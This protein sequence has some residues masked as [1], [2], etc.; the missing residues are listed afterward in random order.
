MGPSTGCVVIE[1]QHHDRTNHGHDHAVEIKTGDAAHPDRAEEGASD[2]RP[3]NAEDDV[4]KEKPWP[5]LL[6]ILLA[7]K[8]EMSPKITY[9]IRDMMH[10][11][12]WIKTPDFMVGPAGRDC[13]RL[14]HS[15]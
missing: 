5:V 9:P 3:D 11:L 2:N 6:T 13:S 1:H 4:D 14:R 7:M 15:Y 12:T 8:P 10:L